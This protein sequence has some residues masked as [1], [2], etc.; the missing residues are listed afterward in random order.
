MFTEIV[1]SIKANL[2][3]RIVSP[4][5]GAFL[6]ALLIVNY[7]TV[8]LIFDSQDFYQKVAYISGTLY[9]D[10]LQSFYK[11]FAIPTAWAVLFILAYPWPSRWAYQY[12]MG[13]QKRLKE[14]K[15]K[16]ENETPLTVQESRELRQQLTVLEE[17]FDK[18]IQAR[19]KE[20]KFLKRENVALLEER[21][22]LVDRVAG[23][24]VTDPEK[25]LRERA[26]ETA[27]N[28]GHKEQN[29]R[30]MSLDSEKN[31]ARI[32]I[33]LCTEP[34]AR[35]PLSTLADRS[36]LSFVRT[37]AI[38]EGLEPLGI[39]ELIKDSSGELVVELT[40]EG[41]DYALRHDLA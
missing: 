15:V 38:A 5:S 10:A 2:Y 7:Q 32:L 30:V 13:Q 19:D 24:A 4:L 18:E 12:W 20:I 36:D 11:L 1:N 9:P 40:R 23:P 34:D 41:R 27:Q 39:V 3:E 37:R 28:M 33:N 17:Q 25:S 29:E 35:M 6:I 8:L 26:L 16:I 22:D 31:V 21:N 14:I